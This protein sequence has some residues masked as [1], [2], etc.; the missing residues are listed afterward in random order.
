MKA[1][2]DYLPALVVV[3]VS[4]EIWE[5]F[6]TRG[7][8]SSS[9]LPSP[10]SIFSTLVSNRSVI[11]VNSLQ[12]L[13][14]TV[15]GL[16]I[17]VL[18]GVAFGIALFL[19]AKLRKVLYPLLVVTQTIPIIA[20][21]P[22]LL[23]WFGFDLTPKVIVVVLYCFYPISI[24][25]S[26]GL[27][28]ADDHLV[29]LMKSLRATRWQTLRYV[30]LPAALPAFFSGLKISTTYAITGAVVGEYVGAYKGLG[31]YME[32]AA[33]ADAINVVFAAI[34]VIV[35]LSLVLLCAVILIEKWSMPW[36]AQRD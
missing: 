4:L 29:D 3:F 12:T 9:V 23:I 6:T 14:E 17:A 24:A 5:I 28:A 36:R 25:V 10:I 15:I 16:M 26:G 19:S 22:L 34:L 27:A 2:K 35:S 33:H 31:I 13:A 32:T 18:L 20:L 8:V 30:Q 21:A 11:W 1:Y 7:F